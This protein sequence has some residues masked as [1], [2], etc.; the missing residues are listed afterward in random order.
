MKG[1]ELNT[2]NYLRIYRLNWLMCGPLLLLFAWPY[3]ILAE[4]LQVTSLLLV[5]GSL[6]FSIP[7]TL[8]VLHGHIS[9]AVGPLHR[10]RYYEWQMNLPGFFK[11]PFH[12]ILFRTRIR[13]SLVTLSLVFLLLDYLLK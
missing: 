6:F 9:V 7:F 11:F 3:V 1:Q 12:P 10:I 13:I 8:T 4:L 2:A 5:T